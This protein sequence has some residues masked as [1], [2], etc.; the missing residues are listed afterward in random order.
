VQ[1]PKSQAPNTKQISNPNSKRSK[2]PRP[3]GRAKQ[4]GSLI[5]YF[6]TRKSTS[7]PTALA[8]RPTDTSLCKN[9]APLHKYRVLNLEF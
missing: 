7:L 6:L 9:K 5:S 8:F 2:R 3:F 4:F 1:N